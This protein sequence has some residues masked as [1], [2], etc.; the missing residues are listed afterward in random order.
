[1]GKGLSQDQMRNP[2]KGSQKAQDPQRTRRLQEPQ[3]QR[4]KNPPR[5]K[6]P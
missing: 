2:H 6:R 5:R 4:R 1:M 3:K